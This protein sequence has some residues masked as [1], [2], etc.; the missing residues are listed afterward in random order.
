MTAQLPLWNRKG[1]IVGY[2]LIDD[3]DYEECS[4]YR[5]RISRSRTRRYPARSF[6]EPLTR[7]FRLVLLH[8]HLLRLTSGSGLECDH[9]NGDALDNRRANLRLVTHAQ[10]MQNLHGP[11]RNS[12]TGYRGV[13]QYK[14]TGRFAAYVRA[15]GKHIHLGSFGTAE[16]ASEAAIAARAK[17][18]THAPES[19]GRV[20]LPNA[21]AA[22]SVN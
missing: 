16:E 1:E 21:I 12:T 19:D 7:E 17:Y 9:I 22:A 6:R 5:W 3:D 20:S 15:H 10:N 11:Y 14:D 8:Q 2:A 4:Q 13:H 18:M